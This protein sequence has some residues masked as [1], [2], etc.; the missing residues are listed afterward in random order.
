MKFVNTLYIFLLVFFFIL[1]PRFQFGVIIHTG[2]MSVALLIIWTAIK[3]PHAFFIYNKLAETIV[4]YLAFAFYSLTLSFLYN[5]DATYFFSI[6]IS[7]II[8]NIFGWLIASYLLNSSADRI[9]ILNQLLAIFVIVAVLNSSIILIEF[10]SPNAKDAIESIL[11]QVE[12]SNINYADHPFRFRGMASAGGAALSVFG[13]VMLIPL[14]FLVINDKIHDGLSLL[15]ALIITCSNIFTGRTGLILSIGLSFCL[16]VIVLV[17]NIRSGFVGFVR[18]LSL[19]IFFV[20]VI[21]LMADFTLDPAVEYWAFEWTRNLESSKIETDSTDAWLGMLFLPDNPIHLVFGVGFFAGTSN[22]YPGTDPGYLKTILSIGVPL[23]ILFYGFIL[24]KFSRM[25][26]LSPKYLLL[27]I[28]FLGVM[29]LLEIKEPFIY[30]NYVGRVIF[31]LT[32]ATMSL[33]WDLDR[34]RPIL[35]S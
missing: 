2:Y 29:I 12:N 31:L 15:A 13:G 24:L 8:Y 3:L 14:I 30:Q 7:A 18:I 6:C 28:T 1:A 33:R 11:L 34:K 32:G 21:I 27:V 22:I 25:I 10:F 20:T 5:H 26:K 19:I 9:K 35:S 17:K 4:V 23:S 16:L